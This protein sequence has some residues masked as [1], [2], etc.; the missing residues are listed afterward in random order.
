MPPFDPLKRNDLVRH[1]R[2]AGFGVQATP[3]DNISTWSKG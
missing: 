2:A 1:L 3:E